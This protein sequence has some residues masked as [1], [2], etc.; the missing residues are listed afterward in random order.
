MIGTIINKEKSDEKDKL[1]H[2]VLHDLENLR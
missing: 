1:Y 2:S